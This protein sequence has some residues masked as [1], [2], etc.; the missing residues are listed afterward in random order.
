MVQ[1]GNLRIDED[2]SKYL[3]VIEIW[4]V[5][6]RHWRGEW[7]AVSSA[8]KRRNMEVLKTRRGFACS[9]FKVNGLPVVVL[10]RYENALTKVI[11]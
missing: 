2:V 9:M 7:G 8:T 6:C 10:T 4:G 1:I 11:L 3:S 5:I